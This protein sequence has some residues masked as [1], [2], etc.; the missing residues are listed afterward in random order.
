MQKELSYSVF[1]AGGKH[2]SL[3]SMKLQPN[4]FPI[5][6]F[7]Q[8]IKAQQRFDGFNEEDKRS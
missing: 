8:V 4:Y 6:H 1:Q 3:D 7:H 5:E 2:F